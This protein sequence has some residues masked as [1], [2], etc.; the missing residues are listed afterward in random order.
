MVEQLTPLSAWFLQTEDEDPTAVMAISSTAVFEGPPPS[1]EEL[2]AHFAGRI[3]LVH[4][5]RQ[6]VRRVPF[7][8]GPPVWEDD[9]H[10]DLS[11]HLRRTALPAPGGDAE[12]HRLIGRIMSQRMDRSRPLW[13]YW[14]VEGLQEGRWALVQKIHHCAVDGVSGTELYQV[15]YDP[16]P[17]PRPPLED[18]WAPEPPVGTVALTARA[19]LGLA[20]APVRG[21][22]A[23]ASLV[24]QPGEL[25]RTVVQT[26]RGSL[27][28]AGALIPASSSSLSGPTSRQRRYTSA[29]VALHDVKAIR[30]EHGV[31]VND[32]ALAAITGGFRTLLL[33]RGEDPDE[34][35]VRTLVPV[36]VRAP[37]EEGIL[38]NRI[39]LMLP[40]LPVEVADPVERLQAV[41]EHVVRAAA[42]GEPV[43]G[44][45]LTSVS[46]YEPYL[47]VALG[48]RLV[49]HVP[50]RQLVTVTTNVPGPREPVYA[51]G[52]RCERILP[53]VPIADRLR[54][55]VA[56]F[57]YCD[58]LA[59]GVTA[60]RDTVPDVDV[61]TR[62]VT[63]AVSELLATVG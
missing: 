45:S 25:G 38:D 17:E 29:V 42:A 57:S 13:E 48:I 31:T 61:F 22:G 18:D 19:V 39:S 2:L 36:S 26:V 60:D 37:G 63:E 23:M 53:Y 51:V 44:T 10:P 34:H 16:D 14:V 58:E 8:L 43:A 28:L 12:L 49:M 15:V 27:A 35:T 3:P 62:G 4:R 55:G 11:W 40:F 50:Q 21:L 59:F 7:D 52:H 56:I 30:R 6:R 32:V 46:V 1:Q 20:S 47:P 5:Y 33:S 24:R 9:P 54:I 41:H